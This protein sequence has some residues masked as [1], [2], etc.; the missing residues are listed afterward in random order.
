MADTG[1]IKEMKDR[2]ER[3]ERARTRVSRSRHR[4][5]TRLNL[6]FAPQA[7]KYVDELLE[8]HQRVQFEAKGTQKKLN[9]LRKRAAAAAEDEA[10]C[11]DAELVIARRQKLK[12]LYAS[13]YDRYQVELEAMGLSLNFE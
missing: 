12:D 2:E 10:R 6:C 7:Q 1:K 3:C 5:S 4:N 9:A 13:D 8:V 11:L